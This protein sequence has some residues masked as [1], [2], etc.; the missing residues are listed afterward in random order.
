MRVQEKV[1]EENVPL[2]MNMHFFDH[3]VALFWTLCKNT[4]NR[5]CACFT[6]HQKYT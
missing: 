2:P 1:Y 6:N 4:E 5:I 3:K